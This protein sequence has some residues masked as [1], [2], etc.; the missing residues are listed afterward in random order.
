MT[1][2]EIES[3]TRHLVD[4]DSTTGCEG[5]VC[6]WTAAWLRAHGWT[7]EEMAVE[8]DR[9]NLFATCGSRP[10][11]VFSTH[12]DCVPPFFPS[13]KEG[14]LLFGRGACD[15]KGIAA[16]QMAAAGLLR[17]EGAPV[18]LLLLVGEEQASDGARVANRHGPGARFLINGEPTENRLGRATRGSFKVKLVARGRAAHSAYPHRGQSAIDTLI[19]AL[20]MLRGL[21]LPVDPELGRTHYNV[22]SIAG[23]LASNIT[24]PHAEALVQFRTVGPLD[25]LRRVLEPLRSYVQLAEVS[26]VPPVRLNVAAGHETE[27]FSYVTDIQLLPRWG[28]PYLMG[29]GS[30]AVAHTDEEHVA[31]DELVTGVTR[32]RRLAAALLKKS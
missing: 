5:D 25:D 12:L 31:V 9:A 11:L 2:A 32:Y 22:G 28:Q 24:A 15:A 19:E 20:T 17:D 7:V 13:R 27:V 6:R 14:G 1:T 21:D 29:P 8:S 30:I 3:L 18:G 4:I 23:G 10:T 26:N 16:A